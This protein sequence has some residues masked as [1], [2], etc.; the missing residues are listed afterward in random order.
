MKS[1]HRVF[2]KTDRIYNIHSTESR[3]GQIVPHMCELFETHSS[4]INNIW[5]HSP[6][7]RASQQGVPC[8]AL[9]TSALEALWDDASRQ[10]KP[11]SPDH[12]VEGSQNPTRNSR[13]S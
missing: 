4:G 11:G 2:C 6:V 9:L 5:G 7:R 12:Q 1:S 10:R 13:V 3:D 8:P